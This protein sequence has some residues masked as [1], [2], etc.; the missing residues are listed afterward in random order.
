MGWSPRLGPISE[1][2]L[3]RASHAAAGVVI[4]VVA[5]E[6][7]PE[8]LDAVPAWIIASAFF[9][10]GM[11]YV[12]VD[13]FVTQPVER[14]A[15]GKPRRIR[16]IYLAVVTDPF[17]DG[18]MI[19]AGASVSAG[20]V[21]QGL[22]PHVDQ[23]RATGTGDGAIAHE[24]NPDTPREYRMLGYCMSTDKPIAPHSQQDPRPT[25]ASALPYA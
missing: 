14:D 25:A 24:D 4:A 19:R 2:W 18:L 3:N 22:R 10:G 9:A 13:R 15:V 8:A 1:A 6:I 17:G 7:M 20:L 23:Q 21:T 16:M 5:V 11:V 12:L